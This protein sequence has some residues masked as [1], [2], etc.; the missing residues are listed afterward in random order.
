[1]SKALDRGTFWKSAVMVPLTSGSATMF[2]PCALANNPKASRTDSSR[3]LNEYSWGCPVP[4]SWLL[5]KVGM[6]WV[7]GKAPSMLGSEA[8]FSFNCRST[9]A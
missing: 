5:S 7:T 4:V 9:G 8:F 3:A 6:R 2:R 1:M